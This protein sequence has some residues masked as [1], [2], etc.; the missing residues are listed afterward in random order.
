MF[1]HAITD[2]PL[3][4]ILLRS[5]GPHLSGLYFVGQKDCP[6]LPGLA[7]MRP[8]HFDPSAGSLRGQPIRSL[9]VQPAGAGDLLPAGLGPAVGRSETAGDGLRILQDD[10]PDEAVAV[11][12]QT[13]R[14][15]SE[16]WQG[17]RQTFDIPLGFQGTPFQKTVW[18]AL[19]G[20]D[21]GRTATYGELARAAG[22]GAGH[23]RAVGAA[24]GRNP[25]SIIIPCHRV[26]AGGGVLNGYSGGLERKLRLLQL[27]GFVAR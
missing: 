22:L 7:P 14:Q 2:S 15:L 18:T 16:Y 26:L 25:I 17:R 23:G 11:L 3:G 13:E 21:W 5:D 1:F 19:L 24:V 4:P 12:T 6:N 9:R 27:E 10:T 20:I 8:A